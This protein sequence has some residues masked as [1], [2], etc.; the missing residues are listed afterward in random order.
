VVTVT[1]NELQGLIT[2]LFSIE[3]SDYGAVYGIEI[4]PRSIHGEIPLHL[5]HFASIKK[6]ASLHN[7]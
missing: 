6:T 2:I 4:N 5:D 3:F 1:K 7:F